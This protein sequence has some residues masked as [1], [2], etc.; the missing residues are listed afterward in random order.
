VALIEGRAEEAVA[1]LEPLG[2][3]YGPATFVKPQPVLARAYAAAGRWAEAAREYERILEERRFHYVWTLPMTP[4]VF[5]LDQ[6]RLAG[7]YERLGNTD[8]ARFWYGRFLSD[9][10]NADP[11]MPEVEDA[12]KRLAA[13]GGPLPDPVGTMHQPGCS[14]RAPGAPRSGSPSTHRMK[15]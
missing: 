13:L 15:I 1:L 5:P 3:D 7:I 12:K 9:W 11:G 4:A 8:R 2:R 6:Y 10:R 14:L